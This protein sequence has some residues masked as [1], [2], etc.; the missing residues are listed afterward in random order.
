MLTRRLFTAT[1]LSSGVMSLSGCDWL[2]FPD[3]QTFDLGANAVDTHMHLFNGRDVPAQGFLRQVVFPELADELPVG[4]VQPLAAMIVDFLLT[5]TRTAGEE[6]ADMGGGA[7]TKALTRP[8]TDEA[9][10]AQAIDGYYGTARDKGVQA[11]QAQRSIIPADAEIATVPLMAPD[12]L[13]LDAMADAAGVPLDEA[14]AGIPA[15]S[16][17]PAA[18]PDA[19]MRSAAPAAA[20]ASL[21]QQ[22]APGLL[23][24]DRQDAAAE[25]LNLAGILQWAVLMTRDRRFI[26]DRARQLYGKQNEAKIFCNYLVDLGMWLDYPE[27][28]T[29]STMRD[30]IEL[31][32]RLAQD[33]RDVLVLNF[34]P[35]CPLRAAMDQGQ[36]MRDVQHAILNRGFAGVKLYPSMGFRPDDNSSISFA[37]ASDAVRRNPPARSALDGALTALYDWCQ[38]NDVP[39]A[40]HGSHSM[41]AGPG[42]EAYCAPWLWKDVLAA[43]PELRVNLAHFG[44]FGDHN[45]ASWQAQLGALMREDINLYFDT[46]YWHEASAVSSAQLR[47]A[48]E[49]LGQNGVAWRRMMYGSDWHMIAREPVQTTYHGQL[50]GF[51]GAVAQGDAGRVGDIMGGNA[52]RWLGLDRPEGDQF[53]RLAARF[54][55]HRI[56]RSLIAPA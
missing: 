7:R 46:G 13:L 32:S 9:R 44:G 42:T 30:Q 55:G 29:Q 53:T 39:I 2:S 52:M 37:H 15:P 28:R 20:S 3:A 14:A 40:T 6:L 41:G 21:G 36:A 34:V 17:A 31:A 12:A 1:A 45:P 47:T 10:L 4:V 50:R 11:R 27:T 35:F 23:Q 56:W 24:P 38:E 22:L 8:D 54:G 25:S 16:I 26:W 51:V 19:R 49:F 5:G 48:Q 43:R 18:A 33:Q